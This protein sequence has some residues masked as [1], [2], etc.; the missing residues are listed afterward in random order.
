MIFLVLLLFTVL[1][2][3]QRYEIYQLYTVA[4]EKLM[5]LKHWK[6]ALTN[7]KRTYV[8]SNFVRDDFSLCFL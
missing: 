2:L 8:I 3:Q 4:R 5:P 7:P 1:R 6:N